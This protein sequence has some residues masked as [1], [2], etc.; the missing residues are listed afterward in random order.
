MRFNREQMDK[1]SDLFMDLAKGLFLAGLAG[2]AISSQINFLLSLK[3]IITAVMFL[4]FSLKA[5]E[6]KEVLK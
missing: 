6:V 1:L 2:P 3:S 4:Y 5:I